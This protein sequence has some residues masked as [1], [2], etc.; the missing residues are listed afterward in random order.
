MFISER[1]N[2]FLGTRTGGNHSLAA[3]E[4]FP[5]DESKRLGAQIVGV[6]A[7]DFRGNER[8]LFQRFIAEQHNFAVGVGSFPCGTGGVVR[9]VVAG[10]QHFF[11]FAHAQA[12]PFQADRAYPPPGYPP[13][14]RKRTR[15][16]GRK[17]FLP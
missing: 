4:W 3:N 9:A 16:C 7:G 12:V 14:E 17:P 5:P 1:L 15:P 6:R 13:R 8:M 10:D 11:G 2:G